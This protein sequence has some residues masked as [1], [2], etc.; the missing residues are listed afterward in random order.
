LK[1]HMNGFFWL[2]VKTKNIFGK[3]S[4]K[5]N[6]C[7]S[8]KMGKCPVSVR[9]YI[10]DVHECGGWGSISEATVYPTREAA[11]IAVEYLNKNMYSPSPSTLEVERFIIGSIEI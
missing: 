6:Y 7:V 10:E 8:I 11:V 3:S 5:G 2:F 9:Y 4:V 1:E